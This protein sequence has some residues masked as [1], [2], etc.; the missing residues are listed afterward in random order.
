MLRRYDV[1]MV[2]D[3]VICGFGRT[4]EMF[5]CDTYG[6]RPD[7]M[8]LA[9]GLS[10]A[11]QPISA[12]MIS[13]DLYQGLLDESRKLGFFAHASTTTGH[14]VAA[15]VALRCQELMEERDI[16][17]HVRSVSPGF[18]QGLADL[19]EHSVDRRRA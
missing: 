5:G 4:G 14:P 12:V 1:L 16:L 9:K 13:E 10:G 3:E 17:G 11:Y 15:A 7:A 18:S 6:I 19:A 8:A 2:A